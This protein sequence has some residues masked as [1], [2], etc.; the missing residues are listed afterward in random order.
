MPSYI[1][2]LRLKNFKPFG[3]NNIAD[4]RLAP[5]TLIYG[6]NSA[7]KSSLVQALRLIR[8]ST[9]AFYAEHGK[10]NDITTR[11]GD[12]D[13][14]GYLSIVHRHNPKATLSIE[15][16]ISDLTG[17]TDGTN[18]NYCFDYAAEREEENYRGVLKTIRISLTNIQ[19]RGSKC[20]G[21]IELKRFEEPPSDF[22]TALNKKP[23]RPAQWAG[24]LFHTTKCN[25]SKIASGLPNN[26]QAAMYHSLN[27][28]ISQLIFGRRPPVDVKGYPEIFFGADYLPIAYIPSKLPPEFKDKLPIGSKE[29]KGGVAD[30]AALLRLGV[31]LNRPILFASRE[32]E[33]TLRNF[34]YLGPL[35]AAPARI[36]ELTNDEIDGVGDQGEH[37]VRILFKDSIRNRRGMKLIGLVNEFFIRLGIPYELSIESLESKREEL[38]KSVIAMSLKDRRNRKLLVSPTDVGTG[39]SQLLPILVE[40]AAACATKQSRSSPTSLICVEQPELHLHPKL[41]AEL[42]DFFIL[43]KTTRDEPPA[44]SQ[45][46]RI[47]GGVQWI[48]ETHSETLMLRFQRRIREGTL[49]NKDLSVIYVDPL[50]NGG[51]QAFELRLGENGDFLDEWP[52]GFFE[53]AFN[54]KF[55][56]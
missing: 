56:V 33:K 16:Q 40:G 22:K 54:E 23:G 24:G 2:L 17:D 36:H 18:I 41:Q 11:G 53:D 6:P 45:T 3:N 21:S 50:P 52:A 39:I 1:S 44:A 34:S 48:L 26:T 27:K 15:L 4:V 46:S 32:L 7:G 10:D 29:S 42:A 47:K 28:F 30:E 9:N 20:K 12:V 43:T 37:A 55:S 49:S 25:I 8:Q 5:I 14:G 31:S 19:L 13:L 38:S 35:R 51:A